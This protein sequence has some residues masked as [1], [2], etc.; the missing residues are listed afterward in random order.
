MTALIERFRS[1]RSELP[2]AKALTAVGILASPY[3]SLGFSPWD[4]VNAA[5]GSSP[6]PLKKKA[7]GTLSKAFVSCAD[8]PE[9]SVGSNREFYMTQP[10]IS[11]ENLSAKCLLT[12]FSLA[13]FQVSGFSAPTPTFPRNC[14]LSLS[15]TRQ[16]RSLSAFTSKLANHC[17]AS[18]LPSWWPEISL[19]D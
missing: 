2:E 12:C 17:H 19:E 6:H 4:T 7:E 9:D 3:A 5:H 14:P 16:V 1:L 8:P 15:Q 11:K 18:I 13:E 10:V